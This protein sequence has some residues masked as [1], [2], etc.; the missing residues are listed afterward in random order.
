MTKEQNNSLQ[1][2]F[3]GIAITVIIALLGAIVGNINSM[4][5]RLFD[6]QRINSEEHKYLDKSFNSLHD[7]T[8]SVRIYEI[9]PNTER[10]KNNETRLNEANL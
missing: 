5:N 10:S 6:M 1:K 8:H 3:N 2:W 7:W 4:N 9:I